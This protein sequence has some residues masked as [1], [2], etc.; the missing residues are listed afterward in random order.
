[1]QREHELDEPGDTRRSLEVADVG[2]DRADRRGC[3]AIAIVAEHRA[4]RVNFQRI[5]QLRPRAMRFDE[6]HV[7]GRDAGALQAPHESRLL[8]PGRSVR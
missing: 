7:L 1:M 5:A 3:A 2:L 6:T 4:K 8:A